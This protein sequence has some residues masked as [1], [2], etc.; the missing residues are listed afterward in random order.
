[1]SAG[2]LS[3]EHVYQAVFRSSLE[4]DFDCGTLS[5][6]EFIERL[7]A[8]FRLEATD[9]EIVGAWCD[10]FSPNQDVVSL[11]P[12]LNTASHRLVLASNTNELHYRWFSRQ[13]ATPLDRFDALV[14]SHQ[15][16]ARKPALAFFET[17]VDASLAR[18]Q[19]SIYIDDRPDFV[20]AAKAIGMTGLVYE[21]SHALMAAL[22]AHGVE[23][24]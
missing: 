15:V 21:S 14:L 10:I 1:L 23:F 13:F 12:R 16:G 22:E 2:D 24:L 4:A 6:S 9:D 11:I 5:P 3:E 18:P 17:C 8:L 20:D 7:R 19:D